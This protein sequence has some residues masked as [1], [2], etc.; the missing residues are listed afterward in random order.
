[1][2]FYRDTKIT[3]KDNDFLLTWLLNES[4]SLWNIDKIR[5]K[6]VFLSDYYIKQSISQEI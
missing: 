6:S 3:L 2:M 1:M 5:K 4:F